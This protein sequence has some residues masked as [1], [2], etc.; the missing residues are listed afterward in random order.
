M[1]SHILYDLDGVVVNSPKHRF[2]ETLA[3]D[4]GASYK[5]DMLPFFE[6]V[7]QDCLIG[8]ADLKASLKPCLSRWRWPGGI[9]EL[10]QY[11][12]AQYSSL[13]EPLLEHVD[14]MRKRGMSCFLVTDNEAHRTAHAWNE[15]DLR[16]HFD[17]IFSSASV[18]HK[19]SSREFWMAVWRGL[20]M[21]HSRKNAVLCFDDD[22]NN[23]KAA[24]EFGF[25]AKLYTD[26]ASYRAV[27]EQIAGAIPH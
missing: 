12:F 6:G 21:T 10:L 18:G 11:W 7:F 20:A 5:D 3:K 15:L 1:I 25:S 26:F 23:V 4:Y 16:L 24:D 27:M 13:N 2:S 8:K 19:K 14:T 22:Q 17:G 9:D